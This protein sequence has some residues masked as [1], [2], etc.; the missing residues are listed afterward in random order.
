LDDTRSGIAHIRRSLTSIRGRGIGSRSWDI[1]SRSR[2][3][4]SR[5]RHNRSRGIGRL[6]S[7]GSRGIGLLSRVDRGAL[8]DHIS[9]K[10]GIIGGSILGGLDTTI[11]QSN[12]VGPSNVTFKN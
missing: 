6:G 5:G 1:G 2:D 11:R 9:N 7:I 10:A 8:E 3:I 4:R 12:G